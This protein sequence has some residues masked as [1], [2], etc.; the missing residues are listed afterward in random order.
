MGYAFFVHYFCNMK[1]AILS[2]LFLVVVIALSAQCELAFDEIDEFDSTRVVGAT[3]LSIGYM[4][5]SKFETID[6]PLLIEEAK[7]LFTY[8]EGDSINSFFLTI[9]TAEYSYLITEKGQNAQI[10]LSNDEVIPLYTVPDNGVF[11]KGTNMRIYQHTCVIPLDLFYKLTN[12]HIDKIRVYYNGSRRTVK[13]SVDQ[14]EKLMEAIKCVGEAAG[15]YP[16]K[17]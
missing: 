3:P 10:K 16:I 4:I 9:A 2:F 5:P 14:K 7:V 11:D 12:H 13:L 15:Q 6:G 17:P 8:S 1:K